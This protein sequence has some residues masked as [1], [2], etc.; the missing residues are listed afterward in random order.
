MTGQDAVTVAET[1]NR[2]LDITGVI[3][4]KME[5]DARGGAALSIKTVTGKP[6]KF[7]GT[8]EGLDALEVFHPDRIAQRILGMG[9]VLTLIERAEAVVDKQQADELARKLQRDEFTLEDFLD[10]IQQIKKM[11]SLEQ[12]INM[13]PGVNKLKQIKDAPRPSEKELVKTEAIIRSMTRK[14]RRNYTII[15]QNR[16]QRI[17]DGSGTTLMEVNRVLKSYAEMLKMMRKLR[18]KPGVLTG[19]KR[20]K[21][22]KG[23][24]R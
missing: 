24:R 11:G 22:P 9:D 15:N 2:D 5:G 13:I 20:R 16:R 21:L 17:A 1:F 3:L 10:Q 23:L 4:T 18:G 6:I 14:E 8:G 19:Q 12:I 7:V